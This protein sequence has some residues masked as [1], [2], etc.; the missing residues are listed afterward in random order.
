V[1][2]EY[3]VVL[4]AVGVG[5]AAALGVGVSSQALLDESLETSVNAGV[6][7]GLVATLIVLG[8]EY[9]RER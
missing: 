5:V 4:G 8:V 6:Q 2:H 3:L 9:T 1:K 7:A